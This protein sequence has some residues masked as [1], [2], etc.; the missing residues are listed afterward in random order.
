MI[1]RTLK[2]II[3]LMAL[4]ALAWAQDNTYDSGGPLMP[5]QAAYDV[6]FY[7]LSL[8]IDPVS[9][10]I[11]GSN[12]ISAT[13][14]KPFSRFVLDFDALFKIDSVYVS[15]LKKLVPSTWE[16]SGSK[17]YIDVKYKQLPGTPFQ[18]RVVYHGTP[19]EAPNPPWSGGFV[20]STTDSGEPWISV[21]CQNN[22]ADIWWPCKDHPSDEPD[23]M[24]LHF[25]IPEHLSCISSGR[26]RDITEHK[27]GTRTFHWFVSTPIN[28]YGLS[29]YVG[30]YIEERYKFTSVSGE[31]LPMSFYYFAEH[32]S[33]LEKFIPQIPRHVRFLE[34]L[35]G[36]YPFR[37][38]KYAA[39]DAPYLG[40]EHQSCIA[41]GNRQGNGVFGYDQGFD[42]L[43]FHELAHEWWGNMLT[44]SDWKDFWLHE[45]FATY[46]EALYAGHLNGQD[47]YDAVMTKF[48]SSIR[49]TKPIAPTESSRTSEIYGGDI[50]YKGA[51]VLHT[52]RY[53]LGDEDFFESLQRFLY[54]E[55]DLKNVNDGSHC[56]LV[57]TEDFI[58]TVQRVSKQ[59]LDWFFAVYLRQ[60]KLPLL[61]TWIKGDS[62]FLAWEI[63]ND[64]PF[65]VDV[66]VKIGDHVYFADMSTGRG[67]LKLDPFVPP[68]IDPE[69]KILKQVQHITVYANGTADTPAKFALEQNYPNPF[70]AETTIVFTLPEPAEVRIEIYN[71]RGELVDIL[72]QA[73]FQPGSHRL[74]WDAAAVAGGTYSCKLTAGDFVDSITMTLVK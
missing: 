56:R 10:S 41:Y 14:I 39:V 32:K 65:P 1:K 27:N 28:N 18:A 17:I 59:Q 36:P 51:W 30:P 9:R 57:S 66:P 73:Y 53:V 64:I 29:F 58:E 40:M 68:R 60:A 43:H 7:E 63:E 24:A 71:L 54:P 31:P 35:L 2:S 15:D 13:V 4:A 11:A 21:A 69:N 8:V 6:T 37:I 70:N 23:S 26:L 48:N 52:L 5:E 74:V 33:E 47:G 3:T 22:G 46:M 16:R 12:T 62:V 55:P 42:A 49:N 45:G 61:Q 38:D 44:A 34:E 67:S 72:A 50:Y 20:W 19:R 25:T